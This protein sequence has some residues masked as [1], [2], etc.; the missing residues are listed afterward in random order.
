MPSRNQRGSTLPR[1]TARAAATPAAPRISRS[2]FLAVAGLAA[3]AAIGLI[4]VGTVERG[5]HQDAPVS[6]A[7][8]GPSADRGQGDPNAPVTIVEYADMQCPVCARYAREVE[9]QIVQRY[10]TSGQVRLEYRTFAFLGD[11]SRLAAAAVEAAADQGQF[12]AYRQA[13]FNA[14]QGEN[15]GGFRKSRLMDIAANMGMDRD[16]FSAGMDAH[17][18]QVDTD[19]AVGRAAGVRATPTFFINGQKVEGLMP[20]DSMARLIDQALAA[21]GV[22]R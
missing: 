8:G 3:V 13:L 10:V 2:R 20:F 9:P 18:A 4:T 17:L 21:K 16:A 6:A 15:Q 7:V 11:E 22:S 19:T 14:Q 1:R 12:L 5:G